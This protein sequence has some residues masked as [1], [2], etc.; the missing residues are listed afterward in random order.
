MSETPS[1]SSFETFDDDLPYARLRPTW[2]DHLA[3][4]AGSVDLGPRRLALGVGGDRRRPA[5]RLAVAGAGAR[6][7]R[8][9]AALH[10]RGVAVG[11]R[12]GRGL[13]PGHAS[14]G[15]G[16]SAGGVPEGRLAGGPRSAPPGRRFRRGRR[17]VGP[18][19][20]PRPGGAVVVH[21]AG[22]VARPGVQQ[23]SGGAR[24]V[25]AVDR[26]GG[27]T[28]DAD[29]ARVNLAAPVQDG[30]QVY[31]P[32][33]GEPMPPPPAGTAPAPGAGGG[34]GSPSGT[35]AGPV[36][37]NTASADELDT[38]PG[39]GPATL[40]GDHR[41][42]PGA[43]AVHVGRPAARRPG[44]RRR[45][46]RRAPRPRHGRMTPTPPRP[47]LGTRPRP[48]FPAS[49]RAPL[50]APPRAPFPASPRHRPLL[51]LAT[52][53]CRSLAAPSALQRSHGG[54][55]VGRRRRCFGG[56]GFRPAERSFGG[57]VRSRLGP[58][59]ARPGRGPGGRAGRGGAC[60]WPG[61]GW[62]GRG[63]AARRSGGG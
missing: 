10:A 57:P 21:V 61:A 11:R 32:R 50:P 51:H 40:G 48:P 63:G 47:R 58:A 25:D 53:R 14:S 36:N 15:V 12:L 22:A 5:G 35:P 27:A 3:A 62:V 2:R 37:L 16:G 28:P 17:W 42:P 59:V 9:V 24:V 55:W 7:G 45:Q 33:V 31:V 46:A 39:V 29:L 49:A 1:G 52:V 43:G 20:A 30:Q 6:A 56:P 23:L 13:R 54:P 19:A 34:A 38:L 18:G 60:P 26:A 41:P 44:H 4:T 8:D